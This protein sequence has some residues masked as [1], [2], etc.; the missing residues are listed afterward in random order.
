MVVT[1]SQALVCMSFLLDMEPSALAAPLSVL[2]AVSRFEISQSDA[3]AKS[4]R[5]L[6]YEGRQAVYD[7]RVAIANWLE[8]DREACVD[9][10]GPGIG[11]DQGAR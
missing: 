2:E 8:I 9:L 7:L 3:A 1:N 11:I 10:L 6:S 4:V 5:E